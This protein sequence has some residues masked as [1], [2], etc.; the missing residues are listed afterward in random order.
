MCSVPVRRRLTGRL[1]REV[2]AGLRWSLSHSAVRLYKFHNLPRDCCTC[3]N[4]FYV[5]FYGRK[6]EIV[7]RLRHI[8]ALC[9]IIYW[10]LFRAGDNKFWLGYVRPTLAGAPTSYYSSLYDFYW[11]TSEI[12][13]LL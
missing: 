7:L 4:S 2:G 12:S 10:Y 11:R 3:N 9:V 1:G 8:I 6:K 13:E 5:E